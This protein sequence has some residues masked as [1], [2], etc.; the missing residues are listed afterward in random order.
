MENQLIKIRDNSSIDNS[1]KIS[2]NESKKVED[3]LRKM[4]Y[5]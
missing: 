4:G 1:I 3:E 5:I 2:N